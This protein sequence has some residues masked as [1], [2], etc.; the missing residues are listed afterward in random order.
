[1][2]EKKVPLHDHAEL[3]RRAEGNA[4]KFTT[5]GKVAVHVTAGTEVSDGKRPFTFA[6]TD[7]GI[8]IPD[9]KKDLLFRAF[10]QVDPSLSR[11]YG[12]TGLGLACG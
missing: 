5:G 4:V 12:G 9:D 6:V 3:R 2:T 7:S 11:S 10:S 1:M 8:G